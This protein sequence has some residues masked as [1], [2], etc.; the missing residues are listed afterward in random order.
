MTVE[1]VVATVTVSESDNGRLLVWIE[2]AT[3]WE[4]ARV[5][6]S[7]WRTFPRHHQATR[8]AR[9]NCIS[10]PPGQ[11]AALERWL[12]SLGPAVEIRRR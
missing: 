9:D 6:H 4:R 3:P 10:M 11:R 2:S 5:A 12:E 7:F 1:G 8:R